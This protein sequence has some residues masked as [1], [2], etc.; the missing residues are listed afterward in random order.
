[1]VLG[2]GQYLGVAVPPGVSDTLGEGPHTIWRPLERSLGLAGNEYRFAG[3]VGCRL[4]VCWPGCLIGIGWPRV[5][6]G[7]GCHVQTPSKKE[8]MAQRRC[9]IGG[10]KRPWAA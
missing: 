9:A 1:M 2:I 8:D 7:A 4:V 10:N 3:F 5:K 6:R